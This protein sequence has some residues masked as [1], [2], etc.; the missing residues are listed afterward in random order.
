MP[1]WNFFKHLI[2]ADGNLVDWFGSTTRPNSRKLIAAIE[3][4]L[5]S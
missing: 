5:N 1:R 2:D 3:Q 4:Q